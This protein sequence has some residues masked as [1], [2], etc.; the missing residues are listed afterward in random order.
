VH[1][2]SAFKGVLSVHGM[3][4]LSNHAHKKWLQHL[5]GFVPRPSWILDP[6][7]KFPTPR[8]AWRLPNIPNN[9]YDRN[10][11]FIILFCYN[12]QF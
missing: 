7:C 8:Y 2:A 1:F 11:L 9:L 4:A 12:F 10:H 5:G 3:L 6:R